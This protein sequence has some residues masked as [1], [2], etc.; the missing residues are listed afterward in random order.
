MASAYRKGLICIELY[1]VQKRGEVIQSL[2]SFSRRDICNLQK[3]GACTS[4]IQISI[5]KVCL[6]IHIPYACLHWVDHL[7]QAGHG[8]QEKTGLCDNGEVHPFLQHP[9]LHWV[10]ALSLAGRLSEG[11]L[12]IMKLETLLE[13]NNFP[14]IP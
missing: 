2:T 14:V 9:F 5:L 11:V 7:Q 6:P 10:E 4:E 12:A 8:Q 3:P 13:V 1:L